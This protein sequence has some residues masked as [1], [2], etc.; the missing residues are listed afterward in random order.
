MTLR[1]LPGK[2]IT[3]HPLDCLGLVDWVCRHS[4]MR[5]GPIRSVSKGGSRSPEPRL[6]CSSLDSGIEP[7]ETGSHCKILKEAL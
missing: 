4:R 3:L 5:E 7:S 6:G 2:C 1:K